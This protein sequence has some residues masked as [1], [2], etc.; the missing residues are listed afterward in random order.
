MGDRNVSGR[1]AGPVAASN[2]SSGMPIEVMLQM[3][4]ANNVLGL[5]RALNQGSYA[6]D[7]LH[8]LLFQA[9]YKDRQ[10]I[11]DMLVDHLRFTI[12]VL[13]CI[14]VDA[15]ECMQAEFA[16]YLLGN[17][18]FRD[19]ALN[20]ALHEASG[21][22]DKGD[23]EDQITALT[24]AGAD[25]GSRDKA[26]RTALEIAKRSGYVTDTLAALLQPCTRPA[27]AQ[28]ATAFTSLAT[29]LQLPPE[30]MHLCMDNIAATDRQTIGAASGTCQ[31][32][33]LLL[34]DKRKWAQSLH[35]AEKLD[36]IPLSRR[37][38]RFHHLLAVVGKASPSSASRQDFGSKVS[39]L[40]KLIPQIRN[41]INEADM[42]AAYQATLK[43]C[44]AMPRQNRLLPDLARTLDCLPL[45]KR[46][47]AAKVLL[48]QV[49]TLNYPDDAMQLL[50]LNCRMVQVCC[51]P[52]QWDLE[53][54]FKVLA[55]NCIALPETMR[56]DKALDMTRM[57]AANED[58]IS[59]EKGWYQLAAVVES[60]AGVDKAK[61]LLDIASHFSD[62]P[63]VGFPWFG[64][65]RWVITQAATLEQSDNC[66]VCHVLAR[67]I[68]WLQVGMR[69]DLFEMLAIHARNFPSD[70]RTRL[71]CVISN[72]FACVP[73]SHE[74]RDRWFRW[75]VAESTT[76]LPE[77]Q[78]QL[79]IELCCRLD[80]LDHK[81]RVDAFLLIVSKMPGLPPAEQYKLVNGRGLFAKISYLSKDSRLGVFK[82][83]ADVVGTM[84]DFYRRPIARFMAGD[85]CLRMI[86]AS[87]ERDKICAALANMLKS[88]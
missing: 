72:Y 18:A 79:L 36:S 46:S 26:G 5:E 34:M 35:W 17:S 39:I 81:P 11:V 16:F 51:M 24:K 71:L 28:L 62:F 25:T 22:K 53:P 38:G 44:V 67:T 63:K 52:N 37:A 21:R 15:L 20:A 8:S 66:R 64:I 43:A 33:Y 7:D 14:V 32:L 29:P 30:I 80:E 69:A 58:E 13:A 10:S 49:R 41:L 27:T 56:L 70:E 48:E 87:P 78:S 1:R 74:V 88:V 83:L 6:Q 50:S 12:D 82:C 54:K 4:K 76:L 75:M 85:E 68:S 57:I 45:A 2:G 65:I 84:P 77:H 55:R 86:P 3:V 42:E 59:Q 61:A 31:Q 19:R 40:C 47:A 60:L 73:N 23:L 9:C